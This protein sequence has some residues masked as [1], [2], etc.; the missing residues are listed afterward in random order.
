[1]KPPSGL[2]FGGTSLRDFLEKSDALNAALALSARLYNFTRMKPPS[3]AQMIAGASIGNALEFFDFITY[4]F[5]ATDIAAAFFPGKDAATK[6]LLT[7]GTFGISFVAR[8]VG[9]LI[10]GHFADR[11]GRA[12]CMILAVSLMTLGSAL[13]TFMPA[14]ASIGLLAPAG[15]VLARLIQGFAL[16]GEFGSSTALMIEH[17]GGRES[18]AASW[19]GT[20]QNIAGL[21][22]SG[23]AW[24]LTALLP[25]PEF[26]QFGFRIAFGIGVIMGPVALL[27]RRRLE[28]APAFLAQQRNPAPKVEGEPSTLGGIAMAA[29]L[30]AIGTAQTYLVVYLPTY[31]T[32]QL[33]M[34]VGSALGAVMLSYLFTLAL[35]PLRL[36]IAHRFDMTHRSR[37]MILS[38]IA[39]MLTGYPAFMVL[40]AWPGAAMLFLLPFFF[41]VLSLP[42]NSPLTGFLGMVFSIRHRGLG[43][44]IGYALGIALFGGFAPFINQWLVNVTGDPRAPGLYLAG[45]SL[46]TITAIYYARRRLP[47]ARLAAAP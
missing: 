34:A 47:P 32:K 23:T 41:T 46:V 2:G 42:Y 5:F 35:L 30:V 21:L 14:R 29:G 7:L 24:L 13:I 19:Q 38:C 36:L 18:F 9:A 12:A 31:A 8:P 26:H 25:A 22:G 28:D 10:L 17:S 45:I 11:R 33:H 6:L 44:S 1:M 16:G 3:R 43:L 40:T 20:S 15:I 37:W 4:G 27:L 39:M